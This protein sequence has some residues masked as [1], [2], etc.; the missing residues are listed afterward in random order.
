M[1]IT[2]IYLIL[3]KLNNFKY[4]GQSKN[5]L[6]RW[7]THKR[8]LRNN[9]H[10]NRHLQNSWNKHG[11]ESFEFSVI[12]TCKQEDLFIK[13]Q[14]WVDTLQPQ[15]NVVLDVDKFGKYEKNYSRLM[16]AD[17]VIPK[18]TFVRPKWH[19]QVYGDGETDATIKRYK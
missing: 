16:D 18:G 9:K 19:R 8:E 5:I 14:Y 11:E 12:E 4:V 15:Y 1:N 10:C 13:E 2:G 7:T 3:N 17:D 6:E